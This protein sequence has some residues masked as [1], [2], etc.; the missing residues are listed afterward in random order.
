MRHDPNELKQYQALSLDHKIAMTQERLR[1]WYRAWKRFEIINLDT[2]KKRYVTFDTR[3]QPEPEI[4]ENEWIGDV[5]D[6]AVYLSF[7][8]G[9]DSTVLKHILENTPGVYDVPSLFV[10][11]G[12]EYP[13][14][15]RFAM[16][17]P[18]VTTVRPEMRFDEVIKKYG[19]PVVSKEVSKYVKEARS[20]LERGDTEYYALQ[21]LKGRL[22]DQY[23]NKSIFNHEK[24]GYLIDAPYKISN[25]CCDVM[26]KRPAKKY[27][28][29]TGRMPIVATMATESRLRHKKWLRV[30]CN[31][32]DQKEPMSQPMSFWTEQDVLRY[33]KETGIEYCSAYGDIVSSDGENDYS[34]TLIEQP[35]RC[36]GCDRTGCVFCAFG[37]HLEKEPN[38]FQR[39]KK[40]HPKQYEYCLGGGEYVDGIWQPNKQGLGMARVLDYVG[41]KY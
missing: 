29:Q 8:G 39:L 24:W 32:F 12:L 31:A 20:A 2:G 30:G 18:N 17:Q 23:G 27:A 15:Q 3:E 21:K 1:D 26:K 35:L 40:T 4:K 5:M 28:K 19:Y 10:N 25:Q 14:I 22:V 13:E 6:G 11:T 34:A 41:V 7:S 36:T 9:K 33:I 16:S 37:A 38:R